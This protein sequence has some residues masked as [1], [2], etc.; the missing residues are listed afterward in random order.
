MAQQEFKNSPISSVFINPSIMEGEMVVPGILIP[1]AAIPINR[2]PPVN[3]TPPYV[4]GDSRIPSILTANPGTWT[5][6][7]KPSFT[8]QWYDGAEPLAGETGKTLLT[9][10]E[11]SDG[12][13]SFEIVGFSSQGAV[14]LQSDPLTVQSV[15]P[16]NI[17]EAS[18]YV[19]TG[20]PIT[21]RSTMVTHRFYVVSGQP[22]ETQQFQAAHDVYVVETV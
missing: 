11:L 9:Y 14:T 5:G 6:S 7:P 19:I 1:G 3:T 17:E 21:A 10:D 2:Y 22:T 16:V 15:Y 20:A 12:D 4:S 8:Y 13:I 18:Y